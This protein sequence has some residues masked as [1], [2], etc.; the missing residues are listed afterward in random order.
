MAE[1]PKV[2]RASQAASNVARPDFKSHAPLPGDLTRSTDALKNPGNGN[3]AKSA[4]AHTW[5]RECWILIVFML[6][7]SMGAIGTLAVTTSLFPIAQNATASAFVTGQ[8]TGA[9]LARK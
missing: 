8:A 9:A 5:P 7:L 6:G 1:A 2:V 4:M 3:K